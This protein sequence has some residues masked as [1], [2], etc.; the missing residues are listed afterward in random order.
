MSTSA[1]V[2]TPQQ[3]FSALVAS[4][5]AARP[6]GPRWDVYERL[7]AEFNRTVP[8]ATPAEYEQAMRTIARA[9]GV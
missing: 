7:K 3:Q 8:D 5:A 2:K 6:D 4:I 9:A 1:P